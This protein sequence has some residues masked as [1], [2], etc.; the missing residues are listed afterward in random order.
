MIYLMTVR[1][2]GK[3]FQLIESCMFNERQRAVSKGY[4]KSTYQGLAI[5]P[6]DKTRPYFRWWTAWELP[7][8]P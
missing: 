8:Q 6:N 3:L 1:M 5:Y 2:N 4:H 7:L